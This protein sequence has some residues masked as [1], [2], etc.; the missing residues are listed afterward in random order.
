MSI[1]NVLW[2]YFKI[3]CCRGS[4]QR[5]AP[6]D[7]MDI[8][9]NTENTDASIAIRRERRA[10]IRRKIDKRRNWYYY[11]LTPFTQVVAE[12]DIISPQ[13]TD[14]ATDG[15]ETNSSLWVHCEKRPRRV[16]DGCCAICICDYEVGN[17]VVQSPLDECPHVFHQECIFRWLVEKRMTS[18]P[19]CRHLFVPRESISD[20]MAAEFG[21]DE[22]NV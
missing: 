1:N 12:E 10:R 13:G 6:R 15:S 2:C 18:C 21:H 5:E 14:E 20:Q 17:K 8:E 9:A 16:A 3:S 7:E 11:S 4:S 22:I 19:V